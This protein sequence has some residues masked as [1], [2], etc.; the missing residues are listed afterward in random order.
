MHPA[1]PGRRRVVLLPGAGCDAGQWAAVAAA[2]AGDHD[3]E[4]RDLPGHHG[5]PPLP[6]AV[7]LEAVAAHLADSLADGLA[8]GPADG[9]AGPAVLVG[10]STGGVVALVVAAR[11]PEL[12]AGL[13]LVDSNV[14]VT[15][16]A[17]AAKRARAGRVRSGPW[18]D[19]LVTSM[20]TAWGEREPQLREEVVA[21]IAATPEEVLRPLWTDVLKL[22]PRPLLAVVRAPLLHLRTTRDV[23]A[24]AL[25]AL[26]PRARSVDL[27]HLGAGHWPHLLEP[28]AVTAR[29]RDFLRGAVGRPSAG[30]L[31]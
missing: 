4:A 25:A 15:A 5:A 7:S 2:L 26:N 1:V 9:P 29:L 30:A 16:D 17:L 19:V 6:G 27:R 11:R 3:V 24:A 28:D 31:R 18:P 8:G 10:H 21:G 20:R 22:D 23:D 12:V 13:V 14:P